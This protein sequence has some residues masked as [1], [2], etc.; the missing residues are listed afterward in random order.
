MQAS[1]LT[2]ALMSGDKVFGEVLAG[3]ERLSRQ[4][5]AFSNFSA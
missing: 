3:P 5:A 1:S 2:S 4:A